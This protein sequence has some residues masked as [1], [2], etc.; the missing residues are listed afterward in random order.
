VNVRWP[1]PTDHFLADWKGEVRSRGNAPWSPERATIRAS[2][3]RCGCPS[4][5]I[6]RSD[7]ERAEG[8]HLMSTSA[9]AVTFQT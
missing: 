4:A 7:R 5:D 8:F 3:E 9:V 1:S 2:A 6:P